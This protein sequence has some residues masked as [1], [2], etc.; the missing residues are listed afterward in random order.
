MLLLKNVALTIGSL[1]AIFVP[2]QGSADDLS[3][4]PFQCETGKNRI[5]L[6]PTSSLNAVCSAAP[7]AIGSYNEE[8]ARSLSKLY[9]S[10]YRVQNEAGLM[11]DL[12]QV[13]QAEAVFDYLCNIGQQ[14]NAIDFLVNN[15]NGELLTSARKFDEINRKIDTLQTEQRALIQNISINTRISTKDF[16]EYP[17]QI[18]LLRREVA[19][20]LTYLTRYE[21]AVQNNRNWLQKSEQDIANLKINYGVAINN[22]QL[23]EDKFDSVRQDIVGINAD[24]LKISNQ[25]LLN[26]VTIGDARNQLSAASATIDKF[27][28]FVDGYNRLPT[29]SEKSRHKADNRATWIIVDNAKT[30]QIRAQKIL[31]IL[32]DEINSLEA[33]IGPLADK[34]RQREAESRIYQRLMD[35]N[36]W[37]MIK[38]KELLVQKDN[39]LQGIEQNIILLNRYK[40]EYNF[41]NKECTEYD[42]AY[43]THLVMLP[44]TKQELYLANQ[45]I[46]E[47]NILLGTLET[48]KEV[49]RVEARKLGQRGANDLSNLIRYLNLLKLRL[50]KWDKQLTNGC[51]VSAADMRS[52]FSS[53][54]EAV[55]FILSSI[56]TSTT[57]F[58]EKSVNQLFFNI[59]NATVEDNFNSKNSV[60]NRKIVKFMDSNLQAVENYKSWIMQSE[61]IV[62]SSREQWQIIYKNIATAKSDATFAARAV[63]DLREK[64]GQ[65][66]FAM[67][68]YEIFKGR[69]GLFLKL[70]INYEELKK[71][72]ESFKLLKEQASVN[73]I[74]AQNQANKYSDE[75]KW[76]QELIISE[77]RKISAYKVAQGKLQPQIGILQSKQPIH[78]FLTSNRVQLQDQSKMDIILANSDDWLGVDWREVANVVEEADSE[79]SAYFAK[80]PGFGTFIK[81]KLASQRSGAQIAQQGLTFNSTINLGETI[82]NGTLE[83]G[84]DSLRLG[85]SLG[86]PNSK[87]VGNYLASQLKEKVQKSLASKF[88]KQP[89]KV[90]EE[91]QQH[92]FEGGVNVTGANREYIAYGAHSKSALLTGRVKIIGQKTDLGAGFYRARIAIYDERLYALQKNDSKITELDK[93]W[94]IKKEPSTF[95]PDN[96]S[97]SQIITAI[98]EA[99][100]NARLEHGALIGRTKEGVLIRFL[101][102]NVGEVKS[103]FPFF[104]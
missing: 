75:A 15:I 70:N 7:Q 90:G 4:P 17:T 81:A 25:I 85:F 5:P 102:D 57:I 36:A 51:I 79:T 44:K 40:Q 28:A 3:D 94:K 29:S 1:V 33:K 100:K 92:I 72:V 83:T 48:E 63:Q 53:E 64:E 38:L 76:L 43:Q 95:F 2:Q 42:A 96:W 31:A 74:N 77:E 37:P 78:L 56:P 26:R 9:F 59:N 32:P 66:K 60:L 86:L 88:I 52:D 68:Q 41:T 16:V 91:L 27:T 87:N 10:T 23:A 14:V 80:I 73:Q 89:F 67:Q 82:I 30:V 103:T 21:S 99:A 98:E 8:L 97:R 46:S 47:V 50:A 93:G 104:E 20:N 11:Q 69:N 12:T 24:L 39:A 22:Y 62:K 84:A 35:N 49:L 6:F 101:V 18:I 61:K 19:K 55:K 58:D 13:Q 65:A 54:I 45:R 71:Q 34:K